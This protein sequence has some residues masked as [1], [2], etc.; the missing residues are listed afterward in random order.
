MLK[1]FGFQVTFVTNQGALLEQHQKKYQIV[2]ISENF[3]ETGFNMLVAY[4]RETAEENQPLL[5]YLGNELASSFVKMG[6]DAH[7]KSPFFF[8]DLMGLL[9]EN[10]KGQS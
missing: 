7:L 2:I 1:H 9:P 10:L 3:K 6:F 4:F 5:I 8:S